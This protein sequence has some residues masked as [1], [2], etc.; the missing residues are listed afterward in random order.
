MTTLEKNIQF[1]WQKQDIKTEIWLCLYDYRG[2]NIHI[3]LVKH[4][5]TGEYTISCQCPSFDL[6]DPNLRNVLQY[7]FIHLRHCKD[8]IIG[9]E[10]KKTIDRTLRFID[11]LKFEPTLMFPED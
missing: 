3:R 11:S 7:V 8:P 2:I 9:I 4:P 1:L 5:V 10:H 6:K